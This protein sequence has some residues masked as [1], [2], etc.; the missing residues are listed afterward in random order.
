V[1]CSYWKCGSESS[2]SKNTLKKWAVRTLTQRNKKVINPYHNNNQHIECNH[3]I[4]TTHFLRGCVLWVFL[5]EFIPIFHCGTCRHYNTDKISFVALCTKLVPMEIV[6]NV[7]I[8][9]TQILNVSYDQIFINGSLNLLGP[10]ST[11]V[12]SISI[13]NVSSNTRTGYISMT[14]GANFNNGGLR[15]VY[16]LLTVGNWNL[17]IMSYG[18]LISRFDSSGLVYFLPPFQQNCLSATTFVEYTMNVI[19]VVDV[20][21]TG[22]P[23]AN[24]CVQCANMSPIGRPFGSVLLLGLCLVISL[25]PQ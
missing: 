13:S 14:G 16:D 9:D 11:I 22:V 20:M 17:P 6:G 2:E 12:V 4:Q 23:C 1:V 8:P 19:I 15:I 7:S 25:L 24:M 18:V 10:S 21:S 5:D 3:F